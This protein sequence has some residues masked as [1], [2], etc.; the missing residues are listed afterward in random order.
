M[1]IAYHG[2]T[3]EIGIALIGDGRAEASQ[4]R[5]RPGSVLTLTG[6]P[7]AFGQSRGYRLNT[8]SST[9][10]AVSPP[11][12]SSPPHRPIGDT[13]AIPRPSLPVTG[14]RPVP[15]LALG[16]LGVAAGFLCLHLVRRPAPRR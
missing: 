2:D 11:S 14:P 16:L 8:H 7:L 5:V 3:A 15:A 1:R 9:T 10:K 13:C 6:Q 12:G 4:E